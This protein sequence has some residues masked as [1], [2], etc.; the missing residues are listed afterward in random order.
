MKKRLNI[1]T[2]T[3]D[4]IGDGS[5]GGGSGLTVKDVLDA[6]LLDSNDT[7]TNPVASILFDDDSI[8]Y[9]DDG[10]L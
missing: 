5:G 10:E 4:Y 7:L 1:F 2:G 9:H 8:L 6:I 3:L